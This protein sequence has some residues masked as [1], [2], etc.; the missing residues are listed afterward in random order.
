MDGRYGLPLEH[1]C[2][3]IFYRDRG[4]VRDA[5]IGVLHKKNSEVL[6]KLAK[7]WYDKDKIC[8]K[9]VNVLQDK[10]ERVDEESIWSF[11][12]TWTFYV[13][14][15]ASGLGSK[16]CESIKKPKHFGEITLQTI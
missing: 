2:S 15:P 11:L 16:T 5:C 8:E 14:E 3:V 7:D 4:F 9:M 6:L 10:I 13:E 1:W 12:Q